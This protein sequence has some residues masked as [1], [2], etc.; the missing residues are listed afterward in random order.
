MSS[1][2][3]NQSLNKLDFCLITSNF[4]HQLSFNI[5]ICPVRCVNNIQ[6]A[7]QNQK[8]LWRC[9]SKPMN[10][11]VAFALSSHQFFYFTKKIIWSD[12]YFCRFS[13]Q[14][15]MQCQSTTW[16]ERETG[17]SLI[18]FNLCTKVFHFEDFHGGRWPKRFSSE[19]CCCVSLNTK[20]LASV[21]REEKVFVLGHFFVSIHPFIHLAG[22]S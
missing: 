2:S 3:L 16:R 14:T 15:F 5:K 13:R 9:I 17:C 11:F 12:F 18:A 1:P 4:R 21:D 22:E 7:V 20:T 19:P 6:P 10:F 8:M